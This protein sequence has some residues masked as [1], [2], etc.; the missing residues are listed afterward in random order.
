MQNQQV[1]EVLAGFVTA[2]AT[3]PTSIS[4]SLVVGIKPLL[5]VWNSGLMGLSS[6]LIGGAPGK[7]PLFEAAFYFITCL[8]GLII[9]SAG[10]TA[11]PMAKI[12]Q[13]L[14][15]EYM[16]FSLIAASVIEML[17]GVLK[18]S[19]FASVIQEPVVS[20]F[21]NALGLFILSSQV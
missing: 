12:F 15:Q 5:G 4:Y 21:L 19:K 17:F 1:K 20:G 9:G 8:L 2:L 18:L 3:L 16:F 13:S 6:G 14:G 10:V 11:L 7:L